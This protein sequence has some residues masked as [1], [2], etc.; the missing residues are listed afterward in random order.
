MVLNV[1]SELRICI[2]SIFCDSNAGSCYDVFLS[3]CA[4]DVARRIIDAIE[5]AS[6]GH[7]GITVSGHPSRNIDRN[8]NWEWGDE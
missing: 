6:G 7:N 1:P 5:D 2:E 4:E 8:P 3:N